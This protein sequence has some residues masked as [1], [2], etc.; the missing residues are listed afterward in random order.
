MVEVCYWV[1][2]FAIGMSAFNCIKHVLLYSEVKNDEVL[3]MRGILI[4]QYL[5]LAVF[6]LSTLCFALLAVFE[7][8]LDWL[9]Y[10]LSTLGVFFH[11][12]YT[13]KLYMHYIRGYK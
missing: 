7:I 6:L 10:P 8:E 11:A 5:S 3:L 1:F 2:I 12:L 9:L 4:K 13:D